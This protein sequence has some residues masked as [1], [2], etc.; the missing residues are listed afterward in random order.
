[1]ERLC[2][3]QTSCYVEVKIGSNNKKRKRKTKCIVET[4]TNT[5]ITQTVVI[6]YIRIHTLVIR[7]LSKFIPW[8]SLGESIY[9]PLFRSKVF[10]FH[11]HIIPLAASQGLTNL[12]SDSLL[13]SRT[14]S[15]LPLYTSK[16]NIP[17]PYMLES[18]GMVHCNRNYSIV[19]HSLLEQHIVAP[20]VFSVRTLFKLH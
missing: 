5:N 4:S 12:P 15:M 16:S 3:M 10:S 20:S 7:F 1:M 14:S 13:R 18:F 19:D 6:R 17:S 11:S 8:H 2:F 9:T